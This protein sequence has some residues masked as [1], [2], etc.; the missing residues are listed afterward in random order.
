M[1]LRLRR[2]KKYDDRKDSSYLPMTLDISI[3]P[4]RGKACIETLKEHAKERVDPEVAKKE[5]YEIFG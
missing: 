4:V 3:P 1:M 5:Y 2:K